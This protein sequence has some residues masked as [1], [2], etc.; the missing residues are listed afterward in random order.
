MQE[1]HCFTFL[2]MLLTGL[3]R[4]RLMLSNVR[5]SPSVLIEFSCDQVDKLDLIG[6]YG[7]RHFFVWSTP[8]GC[9][10]SWRSKPS[11]GVLQDSGQDGGQDPNDGDHKPGDELLPSDSRR[12]RGWIAVV[13]V[14]SM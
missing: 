10:I 7:G 1:K 9:P 13:I 5:H 6:V 4:L 14:V 11:F 8:H 2:M 12:A 3:P